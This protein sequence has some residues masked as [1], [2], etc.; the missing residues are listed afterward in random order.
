MVIAFNRLP[1]TS[2]N[3]AYDIISN[4]T[5]CIETYPI[6]IWMLSCY[7]V[8]TIC[9]LVGNLLVM[10]IILKNKDIRHSSFGVYLFGLAMADFSVA[11]LCLPTYITSTSSFQNHPSGLAG[12]IMCIVLTAY[13]ILFYFE[14]VSIF[15]LVAIS[16]ERYAAVCKPLTTYSKST[17]RRAKRVLYG[18]W[19]LSLIPVTPALYGSRY[20]STQKPSS[21]GAHCAV[22]LFKNG[23]FWNVLYNLLFVLQFILPLIFM[24]FCFAKTK[25]A[26][27]RQM[28]NTGMIQHTQTEVLRHI[29]QREKTLV[30][31]V[32]VVTSF[33]ILWTPNQIVFK[34]YLFN[35]QTS[36]NSNIMQFTVVL[37]FL[38]CCINPIIYAFRSQLFRKGMKNS[39]C[40]HA[41][42]RK[43]KHYLELP[44]D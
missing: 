2:N 7:V 13:N 10:S 6:R 42:L 3:L 25:K 32:I 43:K 18:V 14:I 5:D 36:W 26:L 4:C 27:Q 23:V 28:K 34:L 38:S 35:I 19:L 9:G 21:I 40:F 1:N 39:L 29:K 20:T 11:V 15:T 17:P 8:I 41:C 33:F 16:F 22:T 37:C 12:D 30:T 31:I 44:D 24:I